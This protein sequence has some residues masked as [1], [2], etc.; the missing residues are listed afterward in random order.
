MRLS[1]SNIAWDL[2]EE[3]AVAGLLSTAGVH[4]VDLAPGKYL[5]DPGAAAD[6]EIAAVRRLWR[7]RGFSIVGLQALLFGTSGL[8]LFDDTQGAMFDRLSAICRVGGQL[9][10]GALTFGS[11]RQRDRSGLDDET[12]NRI[13]INFFRRLGDVAAAH[14]TAIC[15]EPNPAAYGCNF[16]TGSGE[17]AAFVQ[18]LGHPAIR[19]QLDVGAIAMNGEDPETVIADAAGLIGHVH[20]SEPMLA[21][22][23]DGGAPHSTVAAAL[24]RLRPEL[25][26]TIEMAASGKEPHLDAVRRAVGFAQRVYACK[27][28]A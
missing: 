9:G 12:A 1:V 10:A 17:V 21:T 2:D 7:D 3:D 20:A 14:G 18:R 24:G 6:A 23:G 19:M 5:P 16:L 8:N 27:S 11:P 26:V 15:L 4:Q 22:L 28:V 13:A 25:T